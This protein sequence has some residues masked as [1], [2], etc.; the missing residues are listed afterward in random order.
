MRQQTYH[1]IQA[2][3]YWFNSRVGIRLATGFA[4]MSALMIMMSLAGAWQLWQQNQQFTDMLDTSVTQMTQLQAIS[5]EVSTVSVAARDALLSSDEA[6]NHASLARIEKG[7]TIVGQQIEILQKA[8]LNEGGEGVKLS[9]ELA[10]RSS[11][12]LVA[13]VKFSRLHK[14]H[15]IEQARALFD[16]DLQ[17]KMTA[18]AETIKAAQTLQVGVLNKQKKAL[19]TRLWSALGLGAAGL[20]VAGMASALMAWLLTRSLTTPVREAVEVVKRVAQG[21]LSTP[22]LVTRHDEIGLLQESMVGMQQQLSALVLDIL[23]TVRNIETT[24]EEIVTGNGDLSERTDRAAQTLHSTTAAMD[25]LAS[26]FEQSAQS[27][28]TAHSLVSQTSQG[29]SRS[30]DVVAQVVQNMQD[31]SAS[32]A[33]ISD[34]IGVI[35]SIAF[36]TNILA[37]NAAVEAARAGEQGRGFAVVAS[38]VRALAQR[39][40]TA[41]REIKS[42]IQASAEKVKAGSALVSEAGDTMGDL[43]RQVQQ[44]STLISDISA[45]SDQQTDG[46]VQVNASVNELDEATQR[47]AALVQHTST[48]AAT[49]KAETHKLSQ[50]VGV[51]QLR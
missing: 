37:L 13:L 21:D 33:K 4:I 24:S 15:R 7:R 40:A 14:A 38:E 12:I 26:T 5:T 28:K 49:L 34:I 19:Q 6:S 17:S 11:G 45:I 22:V 44:V 35:D 3:R 25:V 9:D 29:V 10:N 41:A 46:V 1:P 36:Q 32:S 31:I 47:N 42:L 30:G 8:L 51:F 16:R 50:A 2:L 39:S 27:A 48:A 43:T 23:D 20:G 18:L